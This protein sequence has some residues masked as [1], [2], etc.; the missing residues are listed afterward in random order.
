[1]K[2]LF[3]ILLL[4][5]T[6]SSAKAQLNSAT[7]SN[8]QIYVVVD[9]FRTDLKLFIIKPDKIESIDVFK[10]EQA[11]SKYGSKAAD[12]AVI[13]KTKTGVKLLR[14]NDILTKYNVAAADR[15]LRVCINNTIIKNTGL[16]VIEES[17]LIAVEI[18]TGHNWINAEEANSHERFINI[19]TGTGLPKEN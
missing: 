16:L 12:G 9:S 17:E 8:Q 19:K 7:N 5:V 6:V 2:H 18:T 1:M 11:I 15:T 10:G 13:I 3:C 4:I 14:L